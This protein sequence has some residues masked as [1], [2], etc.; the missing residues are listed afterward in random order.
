MILMNERER[1]KLENPERGKFRWIRNLIR[2]L[3]LE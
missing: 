2:N 1:N 3:S